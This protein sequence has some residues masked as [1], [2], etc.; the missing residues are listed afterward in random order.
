[1]TLKSAAA[2]Q[3]LVLDVDGTMTDGKLYFGPRGEAIKVFHVRDGQG[4]KHLDE[5]GIHVAVI[6]GR[7]SKM[8]SVRCRELGVEHVVQ[9][10]KDKVAA[11]E[12]LRKRLKIDV[13]ESACVGD[14]TADVPLMKVVKLA[15]AVADAHRDALRAAHVVTSLPG[16]QGAVREVCDYLLDARKR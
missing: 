1:M 7:T 5:A 8:V 3:L 9:G 2:I 13:S 12:K 16:G 14:D 10:A 6:S 15:F 4:I 11:F